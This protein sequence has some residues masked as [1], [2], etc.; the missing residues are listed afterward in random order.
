MILINPV[1]RYKNHAISA[2]CDGLYF[3]LGEN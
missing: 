2:D 1:N 3:E